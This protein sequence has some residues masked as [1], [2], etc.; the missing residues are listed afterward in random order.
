VT[1]RHEFYF[2]L[3]NRDDA[4]GQRDLVGW[5][6]RRRA[7]TAVTIVMSGSDVS[8]DLQELGLQLLIAHG[9]EPLRWLFR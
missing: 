9:S 4:S 7:S 5:Q 3:R 6:A 1:D 8:T 2:V